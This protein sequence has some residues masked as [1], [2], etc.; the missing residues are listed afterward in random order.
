MKV[1]ELLLK[2]QEEEL[3]AGCTYCSLKYVITLHVA[4]GK[5]KTN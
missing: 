4:P 1:P 3:L 5:D 2:M